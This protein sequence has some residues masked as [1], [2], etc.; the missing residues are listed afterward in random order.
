MGEKYCKNRHRKERKIYSGEISFSNGNKNM[1]PTAS[2]PHPSRISKTTFHSLI[3]HISSFTNRDNYHKQ[4]L[5]VDK[6]RL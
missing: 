1:K 2:R 6:C 3:K 5:K 4:V